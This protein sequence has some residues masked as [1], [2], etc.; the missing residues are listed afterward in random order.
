M[1]QGPQEAKTAEN[2]GL[3]EIGSTPTIVRTNLK[4]NLSLPFLRL[5]LALSPGISALDG[6][7]W[8]LTHSEN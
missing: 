2:L 1:E 4:S 3:A 8:R 6:S 5:F 7:R